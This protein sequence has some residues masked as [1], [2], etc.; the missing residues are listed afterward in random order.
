MLPNAGE[1]QELEDAPGR[2]HLI[3]L[4]DPCGFPINLIYGQQPREPDDSDKELI[5]NYE[6]D[7]YRVRKFQRFTPG[8]AAVHKV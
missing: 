3:C 1:I 8:P 2:G 5:Y 7:K 6:S 4:I